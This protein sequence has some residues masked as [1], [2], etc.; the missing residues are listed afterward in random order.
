MALLDAFAS[1]RIATAGAEIS[2]CTGGDK[3][4]P[5]LLLL[6]GYPQTRVMWHKLAPLLSPHFAVIMPD[7]RGYGQSAKPEAGENFINYSKR[8]M[9]R[10]MIEVMAE[11]GHDTFQMVGHDRGGRVA[12][13]MAVDWPDKVERLCVLDIAPTRE[14]YAGTDM[15]FA[16]AYWHWFFLIQPAPLPENMIAGDPEGFFFRSMSIGGEASLRSYDYFHEEARALYLAG[17][18]D[19]ETVHAMCNDY[20]ASA[21]IDLDHDEEDIAAGRKITCPLHVIWGKKGV[22]EKCFDPL[23]LWRLRAEKVSGE[24]FECSHYIPEEKPDETAKALLAFLK[25]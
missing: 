24:A 7:L 13:R 2:L 10:D 8:E 21:G 1:R 18:N 3:D 4:G 14:M 11:L 23:A 6:H 12:H 25:H 19:H 5:P 9:A 22:I 15:A 20:R 16:G 17:L